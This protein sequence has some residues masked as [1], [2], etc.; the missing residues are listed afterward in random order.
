MLLTIHPL[1]MPWSWKGRA[2]PLPALWATT[3]PV[4]GTLYLYLSVYGHLAFIIHDMTTVETI[5]N[6]FITLSG[7]QCRAQKFSLMMVNVTLK[8]A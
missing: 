7:F 2:I 5:I 4:T 8:H 1:L 6:N 3:G